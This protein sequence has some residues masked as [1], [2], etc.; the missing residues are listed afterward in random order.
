VPANT[1]VA[2]IGGGP[3]GLMA[4]RTLKRLRPQ[5]R[6]ELFDRDPAGST[7]GFGVSLGGQVLDALKAHDPAVHDDLL[8]LGASRAATQLLI[9]ETGRASWSW[10]GWRT[11][12]IA[13]HKLLDSLRHRAEEAGV[14]IELCAE[15]RYED[16]ADAD[17]VIGA[18]GSS[19]QV[20]SSFASDFEPHAREGTNRIIWLGAAA[21][22]PIMTSTFVIRDTEFG[23]FVTHCYPYG[24]G[25]AT[26]AFECDEATL[27]RS[28][29]TEAGK[30][31]ARQG[32]PDHA[33][34]EF[35]ERVFSDLL[36]GAELQMSNSKWFAFPMIR[37]TRWSTDNVVLVG[38]A[39]HTAHPS[40]G[41][42]TRMAMEDGIALA[43]ALADSPTH[44]AAFARYEADR[45]GK[46]ER[47]QSAALPSQRWWESVDER[48]GLAPSSL[49]MS[50]ISRTG[51]YTSHRFSQRDPDLVRDA[52][53][54][55]NEQAGQDPDAD[56][57]LAPLALDQVTLPGRVIEPGDSPMPHPTVEAVTLS[58]P[59]PDGLVCVYPDRHDPLG[60]PD[61]VEY[62]EC[63]RAQE[64]SAQQGAEREVAGQAARWSFGI[65]V[66]VEHV[67]PDSSAL[68]HLLNKL[69]EHSPF[70]AEFVFVTG[71][72]G[73]SLRD[74]LEIADRV[75]H[76]GDLPVI[77]G[78]PDLDHDHGR[79]ALLSGRCDAFLATATE[80]STS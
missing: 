27:R 38:D 4:G 46:V 14:V 41:S 16:V 62:A 35:L 21:A 57:V 79:T 61:L 56:P 12:S 34:R 54:V 15:R 39:A 30:E 59:L 6:V 20:R 67:L 69:A 42:G 74:A 28:G 8:L 64:I 77:L 24:E 53:R 58:A 45:R 3:A 32:R 5:W 18:D 52:T 50:Y 29:L 10:G 55:F 19:S 31:A 33:S 49:A 22:P 71:A 1:R 66:P 47:L 37:C 70:G 44:Q 80:G 73:G 25:M 7:Y 23:R 63:V 76:Q 2:I 72:R 17:V 75:R 9:T 40:I 60:W 11:L 13:R 65:A 26:L 43:E 68:N 36:G 48:V 51:I 78:H